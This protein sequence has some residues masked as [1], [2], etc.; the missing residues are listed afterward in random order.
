[1]ELRQ[2]TTPVLPLERFVPLTGE[3][4]VRETLA[5]ARRI[6]QAAAGR[7]VWN[8][9]STAV[10]GGVAE[11]LRSMLGYARGAGLDARWAVLDGP[12]EYFRLTKRL[13]NALHGEPGDGLPLG[14]R[15][16]PLYEAVCRENAAQ[17]LARLQP[18]DLVLLHD[19]QTAGLAPH[20][21][22]ARVPVVWRCHVGHDT[23]NVRSREAWRFLAPYLDE[24]RV[25]IFSRRAFV[26]PQLAHA[27]TLVMQPSIDPFSAKNAPLA[28][29][30]RRSILCHAG[31][32][33]C[34]IRGGEPRYQRTDGTTALLEHAADVLSL[35]P[36]PMPEAPLVVQVSRWDTLKD[37]VGVM[38]GF[39]GLCRQRRDRGAQLVL[40]GPNVHAVADDPDGAAVYEETVAS[41]R[42]LPHE[43]RRRIHLAMLPVHDVDENAALV[44]A[45]QREATVVVQKSLQEGFGLT[46]TE[47]M[48]KGRPLVA[49]RVG[50]LQE[51]VEHG[52]TGLLLDDPR[53]E[54]AFAEAL[55]GL[56][57]S[58]ETA[59]RI[60]EAAQ[61]SVRRR[62][63]CLRQLQQYGELFEQLDA[64]GS[65]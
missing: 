43:V 3:A 27:R 45:L 31:L 8:V 2:V 21:L 38:R 17:L 55:A 28:A 36:P 11:T 35:G 60:G 25:A 37:P 13:H 33:L 61:A 48:W 7:R 19:P 42:Q 23:A 5:S 18:R 4:A 52:V 14:D 9:N 51:Q 62:F 15:E 41:W 49:S 22:G 12:P 64:D 16:R 24:V 56:L 26:P 39:A 53:D 57:A 44:N 34:S 29:E 20:L 63:L 47:A 50:G 10:G 30:Q 40:A 54:A 1:M 32:L 58:P 46:A 65:D 6:E 59:R